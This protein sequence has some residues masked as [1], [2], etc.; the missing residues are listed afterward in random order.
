ME[1]KK[2]DEDSTLN[3]GEAAVAMSHAKRLVES[4]VSTNDIGIIAPYAAQ[5]SIWLFLPVNSYSLALAQKV[6]C[7][8]CACLKCLIIILVS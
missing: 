4:G 6:F 1:E 2:D 3:E 5:V 7:F 8:S